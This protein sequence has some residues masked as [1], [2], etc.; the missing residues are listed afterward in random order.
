MQKVEFALV[1][2][3]KQQYNT[4]LIDEMAKQ[5][6]KIVLRLPPYHCELNPIELIQADMKY[7]VAS[8][9]VTFK[10]A[11]MKILQRNGNVVLNMYVKK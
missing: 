8:R 10:F 7:M 9:K 1:K 2:Q 3:H 5:H 4:L 6:N 11:D